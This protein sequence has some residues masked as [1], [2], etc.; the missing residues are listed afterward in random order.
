MPEVGG[1]PCP[2]SSLQA[3]RGEEGGESQDG[4]AWGRMEEGGSQ[5]HLFEAFIQIG[6][7]SFASRGEYFQDTPVHFVGSIVSK[8]EGFRSFW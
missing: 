3:S 7:L 4:G 8:L 5:Q 1:L 6:L 2:D